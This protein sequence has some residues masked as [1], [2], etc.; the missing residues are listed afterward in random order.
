M[1]LDQLDLLVTKYSVE[2]CQAFDYDFRRLRCV[3][4]LV[5]LELLLKQVCPHITDY[6]VHHQLVRFD[7]YSKTDRIEK[8]YRVGTLEIWSVGMGYGVVVEVGH[9]PD[10]ND[11]PSPI[12]HIIKKYSDEDLKICS[13]TFDYELD[14]NIGWTGYR[15]LEEV[16]NLT[17]PKVE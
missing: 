12:A 4:G 1:K 3:S 13:D 14:L 8:I 15:T 7:N 11:T 2:L 17:V 5:A 10:K 6:E 16:E 9:I